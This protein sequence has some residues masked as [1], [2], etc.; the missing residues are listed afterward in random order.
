VGESAEMTINTT[1]GRRGG[2]DL[3]LDPGKE[4]CQNISGEYWGEGGLSKSILRGVVGSRSDLRERFRGK[5]EP[6]NEKVKDLCTG[7]KRK[8]REKLRELEGSVGPTEKGE[9][10]LNWLNYGK[11]SATGVKKTVNPS[12][13]EEGN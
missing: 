10:A 1:R 13:K 5:G 12:G 2:T 7:K 9:T 4:S 3:R 8:A 6:K 11:V